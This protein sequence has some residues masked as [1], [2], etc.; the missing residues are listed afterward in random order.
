MCVCGSL[1]TL[2]DSASQTLTVDLQC[3][4]A[5]SKSVN[6]TQTEC[7]P[8]T[9]P[10]TESIKASERSSMLMPTTTTS[11][12]TTQGEKPNTHKESETSSSK[13]TSKDDI[14]TSGMYNYNCEA[15]FGSVSGILGGLLTAVVVGWIITCVI[16]S[17]RGTHESANLRLA[18]KALRI[19][20]I[21]ML[22]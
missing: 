14:A 3:S 22:S 5:F 7:S 18:I 4:C 9:P 20:T 17:R 10:T 8:E 15:A 16:M 13:P 1:Q 12:L 21:T 11:M 19:E 6:C 2:Q